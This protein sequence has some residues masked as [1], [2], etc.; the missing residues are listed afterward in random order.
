MYEDFLEINKII[1]VLLPS[2]HSDIHFFC[3]ELQHNV[4]YI[5]QCYREPQY[6]V[7]TEQ[8]L[9]RAVN[10]ENCC[11]PQRFAEIS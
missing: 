2:Q 7:S 9:P 8:N 11:C 10:I 1:K 5:N 3:H 6:F 4:Q